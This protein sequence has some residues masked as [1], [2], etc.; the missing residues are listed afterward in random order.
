MA[1]HAMF[2]LTLWHLGMSLHR[3][4]SGT[5]SK[6]VAKNLRSTTVVANEATKFIA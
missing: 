5:P 3:V 2:T 1:L 4:G 6:A